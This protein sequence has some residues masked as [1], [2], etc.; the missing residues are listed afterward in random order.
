M[1][2]F[3]GPLGD[4]AATNTDFRRV[5]CTGPHLKVVLMSLKPDAAI[6][7]EIHKG[8]DQFC[9]IQKGM[10]RLRLG[11]ARISVSAGAGFGVP[12]GMRHIRTNTGK[13]WLR[14]HTIYSPPHHADGLIA[15][16]RAKAMSYLNDG[17][18]VESNET[19]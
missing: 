10:G 2:E 7:S 8:R 15:D 11:F 18:D 12:A 13:K 9:R 16:T 17:T 19:G 14:P 1:Q 3:F 6:G 4:M 5:I